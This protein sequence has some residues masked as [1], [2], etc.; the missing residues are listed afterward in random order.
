MGIYTVG[1]ITASDRA[2]SGLRED[3]S[4]PRIID[5]VESRGHTVSKYIILPD[6][7]NKLKEE[8]IFMCDKLRVN[9]LLTTGG[10]GF[11]RRDVTPEATGS[12]IEKEAPGIAE[13]IRYCSLSITPRAMLSRGVSGIRRET[14]VV[15]LPGSPKAVEEAL[16]F[17]LESVEH[18][19][20][21]L[22]GRVADCG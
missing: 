17:I 16:N 13:A 4:G 5:I 21:V 2:G 20:E 8:M 6:D 15:N 18:G 1:I 14:L 9:L 3:K 22:L 10:T 7:E 12:I 19:L 11:S